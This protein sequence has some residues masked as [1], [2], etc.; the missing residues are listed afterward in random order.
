[1]EFHKTLSDI[2]QSLNKFCDSAQNNFSAV[3]FLSVTATSL[4]KLI[5]QGWAEAEAT[6]LYSK[7]FDS[8]LDKLKSDTQI[9]IGIVMSQ[10]GQNQLSESHVKDFN[11]NTIVGAIS[12]TSTFDSHKLL[13][14]D[15]KARLEKYDKELQ[16]LFEPYVQKKAKGACYIATMAYGDYNHPQVIIL[17]NFRDR[18]LD[19]SVPGRLFIKFYYKH[20]PGLVEILKN[21]KAVNVLIRK[22]LDQFIKLIRR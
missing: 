5:E 3:H 22:T 6:A 8:V 4:N 15:A 2:D 17:R 19:K 11:Y 21:H 20:S 12:L 1:M 13:N 9:Q 10:F 7:I 16:S 18:V 14:A